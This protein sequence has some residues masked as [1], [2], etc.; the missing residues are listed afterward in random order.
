MVKKIMLVDDHPVFSYGL[1]QVINANE[2]LTICAQCDNA[3]DTIQKIGET[4]PDL[5]VVD[6]TLDRRSGIDLIA[7]IKR[8]WHSLH[9]LV[10]SMHDES[11]YAHRAF[12]AGAQGYV[13]K[14]ER[15][16]VMVHAIRQLLNNMQYWNEIDPNELLESDKTHSHSSH[17]ENLLTDREFEIFRM[18]AQG[19]KPKHISESLHLSINTIETHRAHIKKKLKLNTSNDLSMYAIEWNKN[20]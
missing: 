9:I 1:A 20:H 14:D 2:D 15:P 6:I 13:Q 12:H 8:N 11:L 4:N 10:I 5:I 7:E 16:S 19:C 18:I 3:G 17:L